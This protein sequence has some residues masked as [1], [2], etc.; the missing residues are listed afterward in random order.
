MENL[1]MAG[2]GNAEYP[3]VWISRVTHPDR[4]G[5]ACRLVGGDWG[6]TRVEFADGEKITGHRRFIRRAETYQNMRERAVGRK[7][8]GRGRRAY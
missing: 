7:F 8:P 6:Q 4:K 3:Y 5:Q 1:E 2:K